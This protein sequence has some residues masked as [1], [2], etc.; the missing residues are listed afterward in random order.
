MEDEL[1]PQEIVNVMSAVGM[2]SFLAIF[3]LFARA[4]TG[5]SLLAYEPRR[6]TPWGALV[7]AV[8]LGMV[9]MA[10]LQLLLPSSTIE[11]STSSV[12]VSST[13]SFSM[14]QLS[15]VALAI[16]WLEFARD[17]DEHD[18]GLPTSGGQLALDVAIG[19]V[20]CAA[21]LLPVF[22]V[23]LSLVKLFNVQETHP[24]VERLMKSSSSEMLSAAFVAAVISAPIFEEFVFRVLLQGWLERVED[25]ELDF[26]ATE[27]DVAPD[28]APPGTEIQRPANGWLGYLPH[29]W[30]PI[31]ISS[32]LFGLA[33]MGHGIAPIPLVLLGVVLGYVYQRTHRIVPCIVIH[34]LFNAFSMLLLWLSLSTSGE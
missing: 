30:L 4:A 10:F 14:I 19:A 6:R 22:A 15:F 3:F 2:V 12:F 5:R 13:L 34:M 17:A 23:N 25:E 27:R 9:S 21:A 24:M 32:V 7:L 31:M 16:L 28:I 26:Q 1:I 33:H 11:Q 8:P 20:A 29:G 18:L